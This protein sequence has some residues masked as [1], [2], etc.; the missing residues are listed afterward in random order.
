MKLRQWQKE[1]IE[2]L[3]GNGALTS[4]NESDEI[5]AN[6]ILSAPT[7]AGKTAV[8]LNWA[9]ITNPDQRIIL[10]APTK[11][12]SNERFRDLYKVYGDDVGINTGDL[13]INTNAR[14]LCCTQEIY[15]QKYAN[16]P[17]QKVIMDEFHYCFQNPDRIPAY[18][19]G[20]TNTNKDSDILVISAT[21][22]NE[23]ELINQ[24][25]EMKGQKFNLYH[26]DERATELTYHFHDDIYLE[27]MKNCLI[28]A[29]SVRDVMNEA[30]DIA[31]ER[32][33]APIKQPEYKY[34]LIK[35]VANE[36]NVYPENYETLLKQ[37]VGVYYGKL[38]PKEKLFMETIYKAGLI[39][40]M[41]GTDAL[42][43]G[44]NLPCESVYITSLEKGYDEIT[45]SEFQQMAGRAGRFGYFDE[46]HC[47]SYI[48]LDEEDIKY[49]TEGKDEIPNLIE[50]REKM[51][52][53]YPEMV[54][55]NISIPDSCK[56]QEEKIDFINSYISKRI[57]DIQQTKEF[58]NTGYE[59]QGF[60]SLKLE[61]EGIDDASLCIKDGKVIL[62]D[63]D[64]YAAK[65]LLVKLDYPEEYK[66][67]SGSFSG[68]TLYDMLEE[69]NYYDAE[70]D[71]WR[72]D[73]YGDYSYY[74]LTQEKEFN[75]KV[76]NII[77]DISPVSAKVFQDQN[78]DLDEHIKAA[79]PIQDKSSFLQINERLNEITDKDHIKKV[80]IKAFEEQIDY[81]KGNYPPHEAGARLLASMLSYSREDIS[82]KI[83]DRLKEIVKT[84]DFNLTQEMVD[85]VA[86]SNCSDIDKNEE[87]RNYVDK[88]DKL[89]KSDRIKSKIEETKQIKEDFD[90]FLDDIPEPTDDEPPNDIPI[91]EIKR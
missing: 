10:T 71:E 73:E 81:L 66:K 1:A 51:Q 25:E 2:A 82:D 17:N 84:K 28:F 14:V 87:L 54:T 18:V 44:V 79:N 90:E 91:E 62:D 59:P 43:M 80:G 45:P 78:R 20:I 47:Y 27:D 21:F 4:P 60:I 74:E 34:E 63:I 68:G 38:D 76:I 55:P 7:G 53:K 57:E 42:A 35:E 13:K 16:I 46:G 41:V 64:N 49:F 31:E 69:D 58:K 26:T 12:I 22:G 32:Y 72:S 36:L 6:G 67:L 24:L 75:N 88:A 83:S 85:I 8:A 11:A 50:L 61:E 77:K 5:S 3:Q 29:F 37:G 19:D 39:D 48:N 23:N 70:Y 30:Y 89:E 52:V 56:T 65:H 15:T 33:N 86:R 40:V 9:D